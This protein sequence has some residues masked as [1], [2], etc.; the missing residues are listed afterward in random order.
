MGWNRV[1][2]SL[3]SVCRIHPSQTIRQDSHAF[4]WLLCCAAFAVHSAVRESRIHAVVNV[5]Q[6]KKR[7]D[8]TRRQMDFW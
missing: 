8:Y 1:L 3:V 2:S 4:R 7:C 6:G 5:Q